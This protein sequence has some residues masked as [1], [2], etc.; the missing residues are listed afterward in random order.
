[1][2]LYKEYNIIS[3]GGDL[4]REG[5]RPSITT[6][7]KSSPY[8]PLDEDPRGHNSIVID[9]NL[10]RK[11]EDIHKDID[12][13]F[14]VLKMEA[15]ERKEKPWL[16]PKR[17]QFDIYERMINIYDWKKKNPE[18][19]WSEIAKHFFPDE[20]YSP[21]PHKRKP[22]QEKIAMATAINKVIRDYKE[23]TKMIDKGGWRRI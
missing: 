20:V 12:L 11:K 9:I 5:Y 6:V 2:D 7:H 10:D 3:R 13:L 18:A 23:A 21:K 1:M 15:K 22:R 4:I 19:R 8:P 16:K 17:P 14:E